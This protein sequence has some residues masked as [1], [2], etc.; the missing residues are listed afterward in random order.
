MTWKKNFRRGRAVIPSRRAPSPK[1]WRAIARKSPKRFNW[2]TALDSPCEWLETPWHT[3]SSE[4]PGATSANGSWVVDDSTS[5]P[6][7]L[8]DANGQ[9][10]PAGPI[11][12]DLFAPDD[13]VDIDERGQV[14]DVTIARM[15]GYIDFYPMYLTNWVAHNEET[16]MTCLVE[17]SAQQYNGYFVRAG[18]KKDDWVLDT[19]GERYS[20]PRRDPLQSQEWTDARFAKMWMREK[21]NTAHLEFGEY[22]CTTDVIGMC[23]NT[24][25]VINPVVGGGGTLAAGS[26]VIVGNSGG[27][28]VIST[29]CFDYKWNV[30]TGQ[31]T[32]P[33]MRIGHGEADRPFRISLS[34][35]RKW[36]LRE[37]Q[38]LTLWFNYTAPD[39]LGFITGSAGQNLGLHSPAV[40][41]IMR[42]HV[43][44]LLET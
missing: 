39:R 28:G 21:H 4:V 26:G 23:S 9:P 5:P 3:C 41:F 25:G 6:S 10:T 14:D 42:A 1:M 24:T 15:V 22:N 29:T 8:V 44:L 36:R 2:V 19:L 34:S 12:F 7:I 35:K 11:A 40:K 18:L 30:G 31:A 43:K 32:T 37:N 38:G 16:P 17:R 20:K 27:D 13:P 33:V